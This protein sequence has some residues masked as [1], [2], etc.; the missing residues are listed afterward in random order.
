MS[1]ERFEIW[2]K[3]SMTRVSTNSAAVNVEIRFKFLVY[4]I[5]RVLT[6]PLSLQV[7][8]PVATVY[9]GLPR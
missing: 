8:L 3:G 7:A 6:E 9:S 5:Y 1:L 2:F 4:N